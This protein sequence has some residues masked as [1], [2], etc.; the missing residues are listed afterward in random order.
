[1]NVQTATLTREALMIA[2][3]NDYQELMSAFDPHR[4][5]I[6]R[7]AAPAGAMCLLKVRVI[8]PTFILESENDVTPKPVGELTFFV[9]VYEG[10]PRVKPLVYY[11]PNCRLAAV[12]VYTNGAQSTGRWGRDGSLFTLVRETIRAILHDTRVAQY[13]SMSCCRLEAWQKAMEREGMFPSMNLDEFLA[14]KE[15]SVTTAC[16]NGISV[17]KVSPIKEEDT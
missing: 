16:L 4:V 1:M 8:A 3:K 17:R 7:E 2:L 11:P 15:K 12:N 14:K 6:S 9:K 10:Y 5:Q 13:T